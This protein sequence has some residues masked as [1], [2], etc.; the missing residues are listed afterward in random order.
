MSC[1][2]A[3]QIEEMTAERCPRC[4]AKGKGVSLATVGSIAKRSVA[5]E[6]LSRPTYK[7][8]RNVGCPVVYFAPG[9]VIEKDELRVPVNFKDRIYEGPVCYCFGYTVADIKAEIQSEGYSTAAAM[10]TAEIKAGHCACEVKNPA[11]ACCLGDV[12]RAVQSALARRER[13]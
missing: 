4:D 8:C 2:S 6:K 3:L 10:I 1:C 9:I 13:K 5:A 11:G 7:L 12:T